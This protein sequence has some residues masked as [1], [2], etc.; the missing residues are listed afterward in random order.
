MRLIDYWRLWKLYRLQKKLEKIFENP[1]ETVEML[2]RLG[3][4]YIDSMMILQ[5]KDPK[6]FDK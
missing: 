6:N 4:A 2:D 5:G 1:K 3:K